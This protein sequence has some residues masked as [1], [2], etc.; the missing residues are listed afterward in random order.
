MGKAYSR[1]L[2][3]GAIIDLRDV[4][5]LNYNTEFGRP[6]FIIPNVKVDRG[7]VRRDW[8]CNKCHSHARNEWEF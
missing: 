2:I 4:P 8:W 6:L 5:R 1:E 3:A 7:F